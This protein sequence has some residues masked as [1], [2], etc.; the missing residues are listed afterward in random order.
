MDVIDK[1]LGYKN[2]QDENNLTA[3]EKLLKSIMELR[4][5][6]PYYT[7][8]YSC[9]DKEETE[10]IDTMGVS[11]K[12]LVYNKTFVENIALEELNFVNL[13]EIAHIALKH[14]SRGKNKDPKLW[15]I[16]AD[17]MVNKYL[18]E[19]LGE[20]TGRSY[21]GF[22][23]SYVPGESVV[24][25]GKYEVKFLK[26]A[27]YCSSIDLD[28]DT[29][30]NIYNK[31]Y[32]QA[33]TNGYMS[34]KNKIC[35]KG[36][37]KTFHFEI[38]GSAPTND[39]YSVFKMDINASY[40]SPLASD[41]ENSDG[42]SGDLCDSGLSPEESKQASDE[43]AN[44]VKIKAELS[45]QSKNIG[46]GSCKLSFNIGKALKSRLDW[47]KLVQQYCIKMKSS[48]VSFRTPDKRMMYQ[49]AIYPGQ[50]DDELNA[51]RNVKV[52]VDTSG[53]ISDEDLQYFMGQLDELF[54]KYD[55]QA[56]LIYWDTEV[57]SIGEVSSYKDFRYKEAVGR[58][59]TDPACLFEYFE[60]HKCKIKPA[61]II[62]F[63]D[64][65]IDSRYEKY[66][67]KLKFKDT[68]WIM[69]SDHDKGFKPAFGKLGI[70]IYP[71]K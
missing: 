70:P 20:C 54:S 42:Y 17:L 53:S 46:S 51:L 28:E 32:E 45:N 23:G 71:R 13:H 68:I 21:N 16:A 12:T 37:V 10:R 47:K 60:S 56:E 67:N 44:R 29:T 3:E 52:C 36:D 6:L 57:E 8:T 31:L 26:G 7:I 38:T 64:G 61:L 40:T 66:K 59:G 39:K 69:T 19:D 30:E 14:V 25:N 63:T 18:A 15:N 34:E 11:E 1:A 48:D 35:K 24:V 58:G 2:A 49:S 50:V 41:G 27:L 5:F 4:T 9:M 62:V 33:L 43:M 55:T 65:Y 22:T